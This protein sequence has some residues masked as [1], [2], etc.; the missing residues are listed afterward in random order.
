[1]PS[2]DLQ[3]Y[4]PP[5]PLLAV[6]VAGVTRGWLLADRSR[7][8][9][10]S[11]PKLVKILLGF[12]AF[13]F[14][15]SIL[16]R[17]R[18]SAPPS[19]FW[20]LPTTMI[21]FVIGLVLMAARR[22]VGLT[23]AAAAMCVPTVFWL[24]GQHFYLPRTEQINRIALVHRLVPSSESILDGSTGY[25]CLRPHA[26]YFWCIDAHVTA[27]LLRDGL[28]DDL[29]E[30]VLQAKPKLILYDEN[31]HRLVR[32]AE[33][34]IEKLYEPVKIWWDGPPLLLIRRE[35]AGIK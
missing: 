27:L 13:V 30:T 9:G 4:L 34:P 5:I 33:P 23:I 2:V 31:L 26:F 10:Q 22:D 20:L 25:G 12:C 11:K 32:N 14:V 15:V 1:M 28:A 7:L 17:L 18:T 29:L 6:L 24:F 3:T 8:A 21:I 16:F 35:S 19:P